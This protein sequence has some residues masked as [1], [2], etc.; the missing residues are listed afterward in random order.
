MTAVVQL[1]LASMLA[2]LLVPVSAS[3]QQASH[4]PLEQA[5]GAG[6]EMQG[7]EMFR[8]VRETYINQ[9]RRTGKLPEEL[10]AAL[11]L[12][13]VNAVREAPPE[14]RSALMFELA[15]VQRLQGRFEDAIVSYQAAIENAS[16]GNE[17]VFDAWIGI[18]RA[19][20]YGA[21]DH[22][23]A[24]SAFRHAID[25][26]GATPSRKQRYDLADYA[27]QLQ[28][29]RGELDAAL[30]NGLEA[31]RLAET[32]E[33]RFYARL[34]TGDVLQQ[35]VQSCDYRPLMDTK[36]IAG[37]DADRWGA[38][39]R[40]IDAIRSY[41]LGARQMAERLG[42]DFL[43]GLADQQIGG[44]V[45]RQALIEQSASMDRIG[46]AS[47][48][49][50]E[51]VG[52]VL[53][54]EEFVSGASTLTDIPA[55]ADLI[56]SVVADA[57]ADNARATFLRGSKADIE[58]NKVAALEYFERAVDL[59]EKER[60]SLFDLRKRDTVIESRPEFVRDLALR[61]LE[62]YSY[63]KSFAAF[64]SIRARGLGELAAAYETLDLSDAER[65]WL[66][67]L[68]EMESRE[69]AILTTL[70]E[71][72]IAGDAPGSS[73]R[74]LQRLDEVRVQLGERLGDPEFAG[75][76]A[77]LAASHRSTGELADLDRLVRATGIPVLLYWVTPTNVIV[78]VVSSRGTEVRSVFLP[79]VAVIDKVGRVVDSA[80]SP[81]RPFD[82]TA[83]RQLYAYLIKPFEDRLVGDEVVIV[84]QG[85]L[86][87]LP[88]EALIDAQTGQHMAE[89]LAVSY[90]PSAAFA[91]M[92]LRRDPLVLPPVTAIY[93]ATAEDD[94]GEIA[95]LRE[96]PGVQVDAIASNRLSPDEA[97]TMLGG[98]PALHVLL[99][100]DFNA[101]D[102]LQSSVNLA[103]LDLTRRE[104]NALTAA[105]LL[106]ADWR[107]ARLVVF[108]SCEGARMNVRISNEIYGLS[109]APLAGGA[110]AVVMSRWRVRATSSADWMQAFYEALAAGAQS[111]A[112]AAAEAMR[113]MIRE[114][115]SHPFYWA[116]PQVIGR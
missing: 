113:Q 99:H 20:A 84:P 22:G 7:I 45:F 55:L 49:D 6:A 30:I 76:I 82:E 14:E 87:T 107:R 31:N 12:Q 108:S 9:L 88:F 44:L 2:I 10:T 24:A 26:A 23:A 38:C 62:Q 89:K 67:G 34:D 29:G 59:L 66:A 109:W 86:V 80:R 3:S 72:T 112:L 90:A 81:D 57:E 33:E 71:S 15:T 98:K 37:G 27:A 75:A 85:P 11:E 63:D 64:E 40:A 115:A 35:F 39:R 32:D 83:A 105:E 92:A 50:A 110:D 116:G 65:H 13:L 1:Y 21:R 93:D 52:D 18:A 77:R 17:V 74:A 42:W 19:H 53:V 60:T 58:G 96:T 91:A 111:P 28:S 16:G 41:Y 95:R 94:T 61:L 78:W 102:P 43:R 97:I 5:T 114:G 56:G 104:D 106:A 36:T 54:S 69:S 100:G 68:V 46:K 48:F 25:V 4:P 47:V 8:T 103:N 73:D 101:W 70:V 79:E 51:D